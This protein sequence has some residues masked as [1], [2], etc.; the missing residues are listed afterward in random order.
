M[1]T[2]FSLVSPQENKSFEKFIS[3]ISTI[4]KYAAILIL[5]YFIPDAWL[6]GQTQLNEEITGVAEQTTAPY[7]SDYYLYPNPGGAE[8]YI[9]TA[10][11]GVHLAI[12]DLD[13]KKVKEAKICKRLHQKI[14]MESLPPGTYFFKFTDNKGFQETKKWIKQAF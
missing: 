2:L 3:F 4:N 10:R 5:E 11:Q 7:D 8:V 9:S 13:G 6:N 12:Y 14:N 1:Y